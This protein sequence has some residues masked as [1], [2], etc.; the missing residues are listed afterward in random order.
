MTLHSLKIFFVSDITYIKFYRVKQTACRKFMTRKF[1]SWK[2]DLKS[3]NSDVL[4][5]LTF[6]FGEHWRADKLSWKFKRLCQ[7]THLNRLILK[8]R[9]NWLSTHKSR[10]GYGDIT[11]N[12]LSFIQWDYMGKLKL[13]ISCKY[14]LWFVLRFFV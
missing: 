11:E 7:F 3:Q 8:I 5:V 6:A 14:F 4:T 12:I 9:K 13:P 10:Q 2:L 1:N